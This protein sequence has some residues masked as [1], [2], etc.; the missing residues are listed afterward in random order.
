MLV[1]LARIVAMTTTTNLADAKNRLSEIVAEAVTT[2]ERVV[3]TKNGRPAVVILSVDDLESLEE[4]LYWATH[5]DTGT[6]EA[7]AGEFV[8]DD[9]MREMLAARGSLC[10]RRSGRASKRATPAPFPPHDLPRCCHTVRRP[11]PVPSTCQDHRGR[12]RVHLRSAG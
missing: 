9:E 7:N 3:V 1:S 11:L 6:A 5:P 12:R 2:H 10:P 4:T 8:S